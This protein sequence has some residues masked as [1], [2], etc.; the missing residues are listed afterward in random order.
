MVKNPPANTGDVGLIPGSG[1][2]PR[3]GN[4]NP[5]QY[6]CLEKPMD[7]GAWRATVHR[8]SKSQT[9]PKWLGMHAHTIANTLRWFRAHMIYWN[10]YSIGFQLRD[11]VQSPSA[12]YFFFVVFPLWELLEKWGLKIIVNWHGNGILSLPTSFSIA[13]WGCCHFPLSPTPSW[14]PPVEAS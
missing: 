2:S 4:G 8:I 7:R 10:A 6:S 12:M 5:L 3:E 9:Q 1:R 14:P 13:L 11:R